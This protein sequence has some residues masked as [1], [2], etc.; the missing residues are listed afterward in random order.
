[1]TKLGR[2]RSFALGVAVAGVLWFAVV[3]F[4][5][6][7]SGEDHGSVEVGV[8]QNWGTEYGRASASSLFPSFPVT[9]GGA[10]PQFSGGPITSQALGYE[11]R[12][13]TSRFF[14]YRDMPNG[15]YIKSFQ[16]NLDNVLGKNLYV[17]M[18]GRDGI[19]K[20]QT[21][22]LTV[23]QYG[24]AKFQF[25]WDDTPHVFTNT[26][27]SLFT[28]V[29]PGFFTVSAP[30]QTTLSAG[31]STCTFQQIIGGTCALTNTVNGL[32]STATPFSVD[33]RRRMATAGFA[34]T[35]TAN[36]EVSTSYSHED[37]S[38]S[39]P[40]SN[41]SGF[42][43][44]EPI[45]YLTQQVK[46]GV[47][48]G[49]RHWGVQVGFVS[50][51]FDNHITS[52]AWVSPFST[53]AATNHGRIDLY[54]SNTANKV[55]IA[56]A[57][58][59]TKYLRVM[60]SIVPGWMKQN[61]AFLPYTVNSGT[62][63]C[64]GGPCNST[65]VLPAQSYNGSKTT[66]AMNYTVATKPI[67]HVGFTARYRSYDYNNDSPTITFPGA[68]VTDGA[69]FSSGGDSARIS[70]PRSFYR[71]NVEFE[72]AWQFKK[73]DVFKVGYALERM[74]RV[75]RDVSRTQEGILS[76]SLDLN[77][78]KKTLFRLSYKHA[79]RTPSLYKNNDE[80]Y[81][82]GE[83]GTAQ[84]FA[85]RRFD[86]AQRTRDRGEALL[87]VSPTQTLTFSA[88][89]GTDQNAYAS[90]LNATECAAANAEAVAQAGL[91]GVT[92]VAPFNPGCL[93]Y[94][95]LKDISSSYSFDASYSPLP[96]LVIFGEYTHEKFN[97]QQ[98]S[99]DRTYVTSLQA[100][101]A[102][103]RGVIGGY[104]DPSNDWYSWS[105]T[106]I[107]TYSAGVDLYMK[108]KKVALTSFYSLSAA[109]G[110]ILTTLLSDNPTMNVTNVT[111]GALVTPALAGG[112]GYYNYPSTTNRLHQVVTSVKFTLTKNI[113]PRIEYRFERYDQHDWQSDI[114]LPYMS[115]YDPGASY[116]TSA[117]RL[118]GGTQ[119]WL[120]LGADAPSYKSHVLA[121]SVE[122]RF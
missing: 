72:G 93:S 40:F 120:Y 86:E 81:L 83:G 116:G 16:A 78:N 106:R 118:G 110:D 63:G 105:N 77:P 70:V 14:E 2:S 84:M 59:L 60:A 47:E 6:E 97:Y 90:H 22:L 89:Y 61:D 31:A 32:F 25:R 13:G 80:S 113:S 82:N 112:P 74:D 68:V 52:L 35:P 44:P 75:Q 103:I 28:Q 96:Q 11:P 91:S 21:Y 27:Q 26:A 1:M 51:I 17:K 57:F 41:A 67:R 45:N 19:E 34:W 114:M 94:G 15:L 23:G 42:E 66:L 64:P 29:T 10:F 43:F 53:N 99:R 109:T 58:D 49:Q 104:D 48:Y 33:L 111:T 24:K 108:R 62:T 98:R 46:A 5:Q 36:W 73:N 65:A 30:I 69:T 79:E 92:L 100:A 85:F 37:E 76:T 38:G 71:K 101:P 39:R 3:A 18:Q 55:P 50:S 102:V 87:Q 115:A 7:P 107:G 8:R 122:W 9:T 88:V 54:P 95:L 20:D 119:K 12:F 4:G 56:A 121:G 117:A